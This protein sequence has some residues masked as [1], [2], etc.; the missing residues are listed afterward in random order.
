MLDHEF[1]PQD[2]WLTTQ[3]WIKLDDCY[4]QLKKNTEIN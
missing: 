3:T 1:S 4:G 2:S